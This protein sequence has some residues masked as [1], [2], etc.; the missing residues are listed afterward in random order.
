MSVGPLM[1]GDAPRIGQTVDEREFTIVRKGY[2]RGEV[3]DYLV[4]I[5]ANLRRFEEW[6][7]RTN[8]KLANAEEKNQ[9]IDDVDRAMLAVFEARDRVLEQAR[10]DAQEIET[11]TAER[12]RAEAEVTAA[13][14]VADAREDARRISETALAATTPPTAESVLVA[15]RTE[16]DRMLHDA[17]AEADRLIDDSR[18]QSTRLAS[19]DAFLEEGISEI[20]DRSLGSASVSQLIVDIEGSRLHLN[21]SPDEIA[22]SAERNPDTEDGAGEGQSVGVMER[23]MGRLRNEL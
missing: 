6:A 16:A 18:A 20:P 21:E 23:L 3:K 1:T 5:E 9:A 8:A 10:L 12:A 17:R 7:L 19:S 11:E 22:K 15:A 13:E 4:E 14:I 2:D